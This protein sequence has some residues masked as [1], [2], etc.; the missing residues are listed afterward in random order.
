MITDLLASI[1]GEQPLPSPTNGSRPSPIIPKRRAA[2]EP[3]DA[4]PAKTPRTESH[5]SAPSRTNGNSPKPSPRP[6]VGSN[7]NLPSKPAPSQGPPKPTSTSQRPVSRPLKDGPKTSSSSA[8]GGKA[9]PSRTL[10]SRPAN[11]DSGPKT[12]PKKGSFAEIM[13]RANANKGQLETFGKIQHQPIKKVLT[14]K[15]RQQLK[16]QEAR[17][18]KSAAKAGS[19][20]QASGGYTGTAAAASRNG[21]T[22]PGQ[23]PGASSKAPSAK[24]KTPPAPEEK[25]VKKA[26]LATTGYT[27]TARPRPGSATAKAGASSRSG[28]GREQERPRYGGPLSHPRRR[29]EEDE[30]LD[31]FIEYDDEEEPGYG[32]G[33]RY[34]EYDS[35]EE[36]DMEAGISDID[37]EER[38]AQQAAIL[39]D[40][41]EMALEARLKKEKED[42]K[43][44][45]L[46]AVKAKAATR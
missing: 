1:T 22:R 19:R 37:E 46:A 43:R 6:A 2:D 23:R 21:T 42:K 38:R 13:K 31:D 26:A 25:K 30:E 41:R 20:Q 35:E 33:R 36:S 40:R 17:D 28:P 10:A 34:D 24:D 29:T 18:A 8:S 39:E 11:S 45:A 7:S 3:R 16:A 4:P 15:E 27:G 12:E 5:S 14:M 32:Y 9:L 44:Q